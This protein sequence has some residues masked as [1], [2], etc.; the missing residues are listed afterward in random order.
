MSAPAI[1]MAGVGVRYPGSQV[2]LQFT[3]SMLQML[4][5]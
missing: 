4:Q 5:D 2:N 1:A 3:R